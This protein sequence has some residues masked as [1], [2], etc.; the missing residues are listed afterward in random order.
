MHLPSSPKSAACE[1][2]RDYR[3][4]PGRNAVHSEQ[5]RPRGRSERGVKG[6]CR[7]DNGQDEHTA[8]CQRERMSGLHPGSLS[9]F[10]KGRREAAIL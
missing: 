9:V 2:R 8:R 1:Q 10:H 7:R 6:A 3:R 5:R 4:G